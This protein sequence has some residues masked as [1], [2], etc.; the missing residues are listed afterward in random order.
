MSPG[1]H[2]TAPGA[3]MSNETPYNPTVFYQAAADGRVAQ[4]VVCSAEEARALGA[5]WFDSP[6]K[7][8]ASPVAGGFSAFVSPI[9]EPAPVGTPEPPRTQTKKAKKAKGGK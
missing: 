9:T 1:A 3:V 5:G 7:V 8:A 2:V 4:R 6:K